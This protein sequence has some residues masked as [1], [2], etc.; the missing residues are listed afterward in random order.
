MFLKFFFVNS[1]LTCQFFGSVL[2]HLQVFGHFLIVFA[3]LNANLIPFWLGDMICMNSILLNMLI[4]VLWTRIYIV[5]LECSMGIVVGGNILY[6]LVGFC[7]LYSGFYTLGS[8]LTNTFI[9]CSERVLESPVIIVD[10]SF[11]PALF[12]PYI[13]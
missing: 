12:L 11:F 6:I 8:F 1:S 7:W 9:S 13:F 10:L 4:F 3:F 2:F 5:C